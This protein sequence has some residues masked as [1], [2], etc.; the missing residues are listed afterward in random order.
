[1][2][3][4]I[5]KKNKIIIYLFFL[6]ILSTITNQKLDFTKSYPLNIYK[7]DVVGLSNDENLEILNKLDDFLNKNIFTIS[8]DDINMIIS[9]YNIV[10]K[11]NVRKI[12]PSKLKINI[13]PTKFVAKISSNN[14]VLVG[15]NGKLIRAETSIKNLPFIFGEFNSTNFLEFKK[16]IELSKFSFTDFRSIFFYPS[17][18]L[19]IITK[20]DVLIML[21]KNDLLEAV[22]FAHKIINSKEFKNNRIIDLRISNRLIIK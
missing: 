15:S 3:Q 5:D 10:E 1:M 17:N 14:E 13:K 8:S 16:K 19:D 12:Y 6:L 7:I 9:E 11:Y 4:L 22:N 21:P 18:R 20:K 2:L